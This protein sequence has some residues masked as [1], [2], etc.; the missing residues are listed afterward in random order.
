M[1]GLL[2]AAVVALAFACGDTEDPARPGRGDD[3]ENVPPPGTTAPIEPPGAL[4]RIAPPVD[5]VS[6]N[7]A[8][9]QWARIV[10]GVEARAITSYDRGGGNDD[11]FGGTYSELYASGDEHVIFD[12]AGPGVLR[13]L[14]FTSAV[15]GNGPL[16]LGTVKFYFDDEAK[17]R[18]AIDA[19]ALYSGATAPF[20]APLVAGNQVTSGGFASWVP[21]VYRGRLKIT[22]AI[23]PGFYQAFYDTLPPDWD[24]TSGPAGDAELATRFTRVAE[25]NAFST[26]ALADVPLDHAIA[27]AG[28]IDVLR[29]EPTAGTA[30]R[31]EL[32]A[33]RI[34]IFF[35]GATEPQVDVPLGMFFGCGLGETKVRAVP[36]TMDVGR[37][38]SR[39]PMPYW[40]GAH[41]VVSGLA[42]KLSIHV[43]PAREPR[44][45][46]GTLY[47]IYSE[48]KPT[49]AAGDFP[50]ATLTG[51][52]KLVGTVLTV[53]PTAPDDKQWWEGDLRSFVDDAMT[54][55]VHG[56]GHE[57]DHLGGWSNEFLERPFSLPMQ[58]NPKTVILDDPPAGQTNADASMYRL[59]AGIPF[60]RGL[61]HSTEHGPSNQR[62]AGYSAATF[63]YRQPRERLVMTSDVA[64]AESVRLDVRPENIGVKL[65]F[66][67]DGAQTQRLRVSVDGVAVGSWYVPRGVAP[68]GAAESDWF[69]PPQLTNGKSTLAVEL[70]PEG[71][72]GTSRVSA[73]SILP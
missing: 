54:P 33:A 45:D 70:R 52:G 18:Y 40:E 34:R 38:E 72:T 1:R 37:Y 12:A 46:Y 30:T 56:T 23:R 10:P 2:L 63:V 31:A 60:L 50:Y 61:K 44:A 25:A 53:E 73:W 5:V 35:D 24:V 14:W 39:L 4:P 29:F 7:G 71:T 11:G 67:F 32:Q 8:I 43:A 55:N 59:Y 58:G 51:A 66:A 36:W 57:D 48:Q 19:D 47:A 17:P 22:T 13:T 28:A 62:Q 20:V 6:T 42:G 21:L 64:F 3:H 9:D 65:R 69:L 16:S 26:L 41:I 68:A 49:T 27:G 15:D